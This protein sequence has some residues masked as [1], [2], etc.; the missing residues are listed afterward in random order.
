MDQITERVNEAFRGSRDQVE[1]TNRNRRSTPTAP[2]RARTIPCPACR[3]M[4]NSPDARDW[5]RAAKGH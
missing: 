5:H 4:F 1:A 3:Q 2:K